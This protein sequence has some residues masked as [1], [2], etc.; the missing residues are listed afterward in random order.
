MPD[1]NYAKSDGTIVNTADAIERVTSA[2]KTIEVEH[3]NIHEGVLF[4]TYGKFTLVAN[5]GTKSITF[6]TPTTGY[7]HFRPTTLVSSAD[8]LTVEYYEGATVTA[9]TG[10]ALTA[11]NH[12][13]GSSKTSGTTILDAPTITGAGTKFMQIYIPGATGTGGTRSG[14][15]AGLSGSEWVLKQNTVYVVKFTNASTSA[16]D[17]QANFQWYEETAG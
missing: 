4:E 6:K 1:A 12:N 2:Y 14:S 9:A 11:V 5:T 13:R 17:V 3:A 16:N 15:T 10:T 7:V 8:K